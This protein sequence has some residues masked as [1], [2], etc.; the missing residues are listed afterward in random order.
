MPYSIT[1]R[2]GITLQNIPD[3]IAS[4]A[5]EL[6]ARVEKIRAGMQPMEATTAQKVLSSA[7]VRVMKGMKDPIDGLAQLLP[8]GLSFV[9]SLGGLNPNPVSKW[10]GS[11]A[12]RV[13]KL[14]AE[15]EAEYEAARK[16]TTPKTLSA[17]VTGQVDPGT[18]WARL[19][20]NVLSPANAAIAARLPVAAT[21][22]GRIGTGMLGGAAG[23]AA[24]PVDMRNGQDFAT[25]KAAQVGLGMAT[26][27]IATPVLGK[28]AD[29]V[30]A[31]FAGRAANKPID[32]TEVEAVVRK[33]AQESGQR[34]DD[35]APQM[36]AQLRDEAVKSLTAAGRKVDPAALLRKADFDA[37]GIQAT[38]GQITRDA[39]Q[40]AK[41]RNL[42]TMAGVGDPLLQRFEQ[43]G[44][45]LQEK[46]GR[47]ASGA[48]E[49][50]T[51]GQ[52]LAQALKAKDDELRMGV[53]QAY[54]A[55]RDSAGKDVEVPLGGLATDA[56]DVLDRFGDK[57]PSGVLNQLKKYGVLPNQTGQE[58]PRKLFTVEA[59][60]DL[61]KVINSNQSA[62]QATNA[63][64]TALR[65][66]VKNAVTKDEGVDD[67]FSGARKAAAERFRLQEAVPALEAA[68]NGSVAADDFVKKFVLNGKTAD[69][70]GLAKVL[71]D[72]S[73]E[74][75]Q[76][77]RAQIGAQLQRAAFG[78][79]LAGDKAFS[80]ERYAK[81]LRDMGP[82]KLGAFFE[83]GEIAQLQRLARLGSY[84]NAMPNASPVQSSNN[85][86]AIMT[87]ASRVPGVSPVVGLANTAKTAIGNQ[88]AVNRS[89]AAQVPKAQSQMT[90]EQIAMVAKLLGG[91]GAATGGAA[92]QPLK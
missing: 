80:A 16:A 34:W 76:E 22:L 44:Q 45:Q 46:V 86:G 36:Q 56:A 20:G 24:T 50:F 64:L 91:A 27:G 18:D 23:G 61:I 2:D 66:S 59:A 92:A 11:E 57:V 48:S 60:D 29:K 62:D 67:V 7:P 47:Y 14:N 37:E 90:P 33:V 31:Y 5:P 26:G 52:K 55:A 38:T 68:S 43:Q 73:P 49:N 85:W 77:A 6:K 74:A 9:S 40:Y 83:K 58:A 88:S 3:E 12:G 10:L 39:G 82:E 41:E 69:V 81:A 21:T 17:L 54:K 79:N 25:A 4:D 89:L 53:S 19:G 28:V 72:S 13:D 30:G 63:A 84:I 87:L 8:R 15:G 35:M 75:Y 70:Q 65:N 51:A 1:T 42:R 71:K 78:E 32:V